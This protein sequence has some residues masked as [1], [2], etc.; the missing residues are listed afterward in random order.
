LKYHLPDSPE[1]RA[2]VW[3]ESLRRIEGARWHVATERIRL[4]LAIIDLENREAL[5]VNTRSER[6]ALKKAELENRMKELCLDHQETKLREAI[7]GVC[8]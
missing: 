5:G 1:A 7:D 8:I 6:S 4:D 3:R 2:A